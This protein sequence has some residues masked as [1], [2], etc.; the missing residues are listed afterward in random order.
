MEKRG[1]PGCANQRLAGFPL[2]A[3]LDPT[4]GNPWSAKLQPNSDFFPL[5]RLILHEGMVSSTFR[6]IPMMTILLAPL[7]ARKE[8]LSNKR[9]D[10]ILRE[11]SAVGMGKPKTQGRKNIT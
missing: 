8:Q 4:E 1:N 7:P 6:K 11:V 10:E 9:T 3:G 5:R 2:T